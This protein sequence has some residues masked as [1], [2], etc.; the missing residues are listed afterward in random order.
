MQ[1]LR[2]AGTVQPAGRHLGLAR[3]RRDRPV[4]HGLAVPAAHAD[5]R[6]GSRG[7]DGFIRPPRA[8]RARVAL[9]QGAGPNGWPQGRA[10]ASAASLGDAGQVLP[11][12]GGQVQGVLQGHGK[13][14]SGGLG[15]G[16]RIITHHWVHDH[17]LD[18][19]VHPKGF[20]IDFV[21]FHIIPAIP[22]KYI[23]RDQRLTRYP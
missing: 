13:P 18:G 15:H 20:F 21:K 11:F 10:P 23:P 5:R 4:V 17:V 3:P 14:S 16:I 19:E 2:F 8:L 12:G 22:F 7:R 6:D 9:E 1:E